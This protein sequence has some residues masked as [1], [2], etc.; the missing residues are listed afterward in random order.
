MEKY[1]QIEKSGRKATVYIYG[2]ITDEN[3]SESDVSAISFR[4][5]LSTIKAVE[6]I[7]VRVQSYGGSV[8]SGVA[9]YNMLKNHKAM[10]TVYIDGVACSIATVIAMAGDKVIMPSNSMMMIHNP[11]SS[12]SY[13]NSNELRKMADTLD[14]IRESSIDAYLSKSNGKITREKLIE[15]LDEETW[16]SAEECKNYG[17]CDEVTNQVE[18]VAKFNES[19]YIN[20]LKNNP[21]KFEEKKEE[22]DM[23]KI[24][25]IETLEE[26]KEQQ[27]EFINEH[28]NCTHEQLMKDYPFYSSLVDKIEMSEI[29]EFERKLHEEEQ[30]LKM[31][32]TKDKQQHFY[33]DGKKVQ[34]L[35]PEQKLTVP[36]QSKFEQK[37]FSDMSIGKLVKGMATGKWNG[38]EKEQQVVA[39]NRDGSGGVLIPAPLSNELINMVRAQSVLMTAGAKTVPMTSSTLVFAKQTGDIKPHWKKEGAPINET[40]ADF[41][42]VKFEAK[43]LVGMSDI[44]IELLEDAL[45]ID[46]I[47]TQSIVNALA[48]ELDRVGLL[49]A[50]TEIEPKGIYNREGIQKQ[51]VGKALEN[52]KEFSKAVT[53]I[54]SANGTPNGVICSPRTYG[55]LDALTDVSGQ[56]LNAPKSYENLTHKLT[57]TQVPNDLGAENDGSF[58][59]VGDFTKLWYGVRTGVT[60]EVTR[61]AGDAFSNLKYKIRAYL[62]ADVQTIHEPHFIILDDI[63]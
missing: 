23:M 8:F 19:T 30:S 36:N 15:L 5:D 46:Q 2:D 7:E 14:K 4:N 11:M 52:Y 51:T 34:V 21:I 63:K 50:G 13:G 17:F 48:L 59:V 24:R 47:V 55:E 42:P 1:Y 38:A 25:K 43:T 16:L 62:R 39:A 41:E 27:E 57:T 33:K 9:I 22:K 60:I 3:Y 40:D 6:E 32:S 45:N 54:L 49:G 20:S 37:E 28:K 35:S 12:L 29:K 56:P 58:A 31:D 44:T 61:V 18:L 10:I 26:L 53:S